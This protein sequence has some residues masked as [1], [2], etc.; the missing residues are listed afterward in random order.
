MKKTLL[1]E[2]MSC[3]HCEKAVKGA[4]GELDGVKNVL[5][6]LETKEV[7]VEG[8]N[9]EDSILKDAIEDA[10]YDVIKFI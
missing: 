8:D 2:G 1:V 9:L 7:Q 3:E 5:V 4:L 6:N 10:G